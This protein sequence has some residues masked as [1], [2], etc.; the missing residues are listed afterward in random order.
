MLEDINNI[1]IN[2]NYLRKFGIF[3]GLILIII[4]GLFF[5]KED[6]YQILIFLSALLIILGFVAPNILRPVYW[7]WVIFGIILGWFVTRI[8]LSIIFY[9]ILTPIGLISRM[10]GKQFLMLK[11]SEKKKS[12]WNMKDPQSLEYKN[13]EKQF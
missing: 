5:W 1:K 4:T 12:Y 11:N 7:V 2:N 6:I 8:L 9:L 3:T 13:Y 10:F